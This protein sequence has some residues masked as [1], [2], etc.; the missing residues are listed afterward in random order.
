VQLLSNDNLNRLWPFFANRVI[1]V[2]RE[3][4]LQKKLPNTATELKQLVGFGTKAD[5]EL[6]KKRMDSES[7]FI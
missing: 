5:L 7:S 6:A 4:L 3:Q 2:V 1:G